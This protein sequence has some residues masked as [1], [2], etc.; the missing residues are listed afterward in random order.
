VRRP[1]LRPVVRLD[2]HQAAHHR[3]GARHPDEA[4]A[5][6][7][8]GRVDDGAGQQSGERVVGAQE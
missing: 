3:A 7:P 5:E 6:Q 2:L 1:V 4:R 8:A